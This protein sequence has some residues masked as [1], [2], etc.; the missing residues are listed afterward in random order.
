MNG[1]QLEIGDLG[2]RINEAHRLAITH[3]GEAVGH[4]IACGQMLLEAKAALPH[5][6]WLPWLRD[7]IAFGE[8]SDS[9]SRSAAL[10]YGEAALLRS[11][12]GTH[13][14]ARRAPQRARGAGPGSWGMGEARS[15]IVCEN[16]IGE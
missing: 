8:S 2:A 10:S 7:N 14:P 1:T 16:L 3:A 13:K 9:P 15:L 4:A 6:R 5:G 11:L 12:Q